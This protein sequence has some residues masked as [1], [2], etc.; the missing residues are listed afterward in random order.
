MIAVV[1]PTRA[2]SDDEV[3]IEGDLSIELTVCELQ[4]I[5]AALVHEQI[6]LGELSVADQFRLECVER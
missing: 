6:Q 4:E 5:E 1:R 2:L 3:L